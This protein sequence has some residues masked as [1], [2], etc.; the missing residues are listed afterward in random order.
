[1][2]PADP[3]ELSFMPVKTAAGCILGAETSLRLLTP[4]KAVQKSGWHFYKDN[5]VQ[6]R[7]CSCNAKMMRESTHLG[8]LCEAIKCFEQF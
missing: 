1:M 5:C 4:V 8:N 6:L 7:L 2:V 3:A